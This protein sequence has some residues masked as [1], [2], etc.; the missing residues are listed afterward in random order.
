[1]IKDPEDIIRYLD[2]ELGPEEAKEMLTEIN[3]NNKLSKELESLKDII[4]G[5][6]QAGEQQLRN[7]INEMM[8]GHNR[9]KVRMWTWIGGLGMAALIVAAVIILKPGRQELQFNEDNMIK[10]DS[11]V[12]KPDTTESL[13]NNVDKKLN[14]E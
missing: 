7:E 10:N 5:I 12:Y 1:M 2:G 9:G 6:E 8:I 3:S 4:T 13:K 14:L 11:G